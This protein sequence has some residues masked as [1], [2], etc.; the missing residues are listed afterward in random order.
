M[1]LNVFMANFTV[2]FVEI[3][4][5]R[6]AD[7]AMPPLRQPSRGGI[8]LDPSVKAIPAAF[9]KRLA[10]FAFLNIVHVLI[11][12]PP[13]NERLVGPKHSCK[14]SMQLFIRRKGF[15]AVS[16]T[17]RVPFFITSRELS[18]AQPNLS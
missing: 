7:V 6:L 3:E 10:D 9:F 14:V 17:K 12:S 11:R 8:S 15:K 2:C 16:L 4:V 1:G 5:T 18:T 13:E